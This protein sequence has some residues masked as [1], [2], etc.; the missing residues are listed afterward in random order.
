M[1]DN[2]IRYNSDG[3][4]QYRDDTIKQIFKEIHEIDFGDYSIE[5]SEGSEI[6]TDF[7][8]PP[9]VVSLTN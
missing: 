5:V 9:D 8:P 1:S 6:Q 2:S 3:T 4:F 7:T